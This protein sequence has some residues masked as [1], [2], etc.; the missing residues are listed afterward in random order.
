[1]TELD[2]A[3]L[4]ALVSPLRRTLLGAARAAERLPDIPDAQVEVIRALPRGAAHSPGELA[5]L[6]GLSRSAVSNLLAAMEKRGLVTRR[7]K[8]GDRRQV[9]VVATPTAH[10]LFDRF[11]AASVALVGAAAADLDPADRDVLAAAIPALERLRDALAARRRPETSPIP[12]HA[13]ETE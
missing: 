13:T 3:R 9:E 4:S 7:A 8:T 5:A 11:D 2:A 10:G 1:M 12:D 6:L